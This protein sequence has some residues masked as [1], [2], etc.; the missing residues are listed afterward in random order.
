M[1]I[2]DSAYSQQPKWIIEESKAEVGAI[3][4]LVTILKSIYS[5]IHEHVLTAFFKL[6]IYNKILTMAAG[7]VNSIFEVLESEM[8]MEARKNVAAEIYDR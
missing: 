8:T 1:G 5:R 3:P 6:S 4:F 7:A 2:R